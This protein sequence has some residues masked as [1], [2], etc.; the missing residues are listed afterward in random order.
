MADMQQILLIPCTPC[1]RHH[2]RCEQPH[3]PTTCGARCSRSGARSCASGWASVL[4]TYGTK[5]RCVCVC[6]CE[7]GRLVR[8]AQNEKESEKLIDSQHQGAA[9]VHCPAALLP[10][11]AKHF[12][13]FEGGAVALPLAPSF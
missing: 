10:S 5:C 13:T 1:K 6:V 7:G 11:A 2:R 8:C 9:A 4:V 12:E 3:G